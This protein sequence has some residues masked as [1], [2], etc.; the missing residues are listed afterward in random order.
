MLLRKRA[1]DIMNEEFSTIEDSA[2]LA[3]AVRSLR[4]SMKEMPDNHIV[5]V[6]K[7]NGSLRGVVSI[8]TLLKAVEDMVLKDE[9]LTL[10][11]E[12]DWD[13]AFKRAGTAC[14]SASLDNHI[15]EDVV[16]L[17]PTDPMLVVLEIFRKKKRT[18]A[19]VQEGG[20]IIGVVLLSDVYR[21]VTRDL[22]QQ[23]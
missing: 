12:A 5:V 23:F 16:I 1:W 13:R 11:E 8:W 15:E 6:K 20:N 4:D 22:V 3:E 19:L 18:W 9:D 14:C 17:K 21:E 7:K 10:T 2:S